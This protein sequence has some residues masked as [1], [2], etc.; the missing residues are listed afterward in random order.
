MIEHI[1]QA[2]IDS[3]IA[4]GICAY[5]GLKENLVT[6]NYQD[7]NAIYIIAI[8]GITGLVVMEALKWI[9]WRFFRQ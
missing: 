1:I 4:A 3:L 8:Y 9:K 6:V 5:L 7:S 2:K